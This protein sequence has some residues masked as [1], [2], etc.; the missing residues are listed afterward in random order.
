MGMKPTVKLSRSQYMQ[1]HLHTGY[2][3]QGTRSVEPL[4]L[5]EFRHGPPA[6]YLDSLCQV[7][8]AAENRTRTRRIVRV[9]CVVFHA[10]LAVVRLYD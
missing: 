7:L 2:K 1:R 3:C 10:A 5:A 9:S 6:G 8:I 4:S